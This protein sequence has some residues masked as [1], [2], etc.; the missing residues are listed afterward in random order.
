MFPRE[1]KLDRAPTGSGHIKGLGLRGFLAWYGASID[2]ERVLEALG[3]A[4]RHFSEYF[5]VSQPGFGVLTSRWYPAEVVHAIFD[6]I[7]RHHSSTERPRLA[8]HG[9]QAV[10][11][12]LLQGVYRTVISMF[13][14]PERYARHGEKLWTLNY[15]NGRPVSVTSPTEHRVTYIE[16]RSHHPF[17]CR[18]NMATA[19]ALYTA[20]GCRDVRYR[21]L[22]CISD[23]AEAC[24]SV[25]S[26]K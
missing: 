17:L 20:M 2:R 14:T 18:I 22:G 1:R 15:D 3:L 25:I 8:E 13:A 23:G 7:L 11:N 16:W 6:E 19:L 9:A 24:D 4:Q 10:M 21:R 12:D 5:D 26:W